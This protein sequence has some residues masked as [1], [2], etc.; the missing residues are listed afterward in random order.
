MLVGGR[1]KIGLLI[2]NFLPPA[3][4]WTQHRKGSLSGNLTESQVHSMSKVEGSN[5]LI[6]MRK[7]RPS[8]GKGPAPKV[9]QFCHPE[10]QL[11][12]HSRADLASAT[13]TMQG[14]LS[15]SASS[16]IAPWYHLSATNSFFLVVLRIRQQC[17]KEIQKATEAQRMNL[18]LLHSCTLELW[19]LNS[20]L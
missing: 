14:S 13:I 12:S 16:T 6:I 17:H 9:S 8:E 7:F 11:A 20:E 3:L 4:S 18:H 10:N 1:K 5:V 19:T 2:P 15:R